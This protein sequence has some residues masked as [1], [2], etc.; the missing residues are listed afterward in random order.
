MVLLLPDRRGT[1]VPD[2]KVTVSGDYSGRAASGDC[3]LAHTNGEC[4]MPAEVLAA[5]PPGWPQWVDQDD[6]EVIR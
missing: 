5:P 6:F 3:R 1:V 4:L 2:A